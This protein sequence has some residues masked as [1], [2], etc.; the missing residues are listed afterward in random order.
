[1]DA[2]ATPEILRLLNEVPDPRGPNCLH[3]LHD[4][5]CIALMAVIS[6]CCGWVDVE[7]FALVRQ[8]WLQTFLDLPSG[9]PSHDTFGRVFARLD[10]EAFEAVLL[11]WTGQLADLSGG[12]LVALDGKSIRRSFENAWD[13]A[14]MAHIVSAFM[15]AN[16]LCL[17][18]VKCDGKGQELQ[19]MEKL[20]AL[21]DVTG[22]VVS[23]DAIGCNAHMAGVITKA[24]A[25]YVLQVKENQPTLLAKCQ[26][27]FAEAILEKFQGCVCDTHQHV[28]SDHGRIETR[29]ITVLWNPELLGELQSDWSNLKCLVRLENTRETPG[30]KAMKVQQETHYYIST[31]DSRHNAQT[32]LSYVR[33]HWSVENNL[34]WHLDVTFGEDDRRLRKGHG[35]EN[36]SRLSRVALNLL[37]AEKTPQKSI[38]V[39]RKLCG[40]SAD[41]LLKVLTS[42]S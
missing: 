41:F 35:A 30:P 33:G 22:A 40:W 19:A 28:A 24:R 15:Q 18:Q 6:G 20:L 5:L 39:K 4:I 13:K 12:K 14:G 29:N 7:E 9:I 38:R 36:F 16:S 17:A 27:I 32:M 21:V 8:D 26:T 2:T 31:L 10:P 1:M 25:G 37:K 23:I 11:K 42:L 34:H 3:Q